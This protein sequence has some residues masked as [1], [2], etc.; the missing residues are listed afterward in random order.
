MLAVCLIANDL[1]QMNARRQ[2]T[3]EARIMLETASAMRGYTATQIEPLLAPQ[4]PHKFLPQAVTSY[5]T[6][7]IFDDIRQ[8]YP[9][10]TYREAALNP[11][12]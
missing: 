11:K 3:Q 8:K 10:Y 1:F 12:N 6:A 4:F 2:V 7:Q 9:D 5:A